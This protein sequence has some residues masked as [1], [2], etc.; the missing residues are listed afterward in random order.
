MPIVD[1]VSEGLKQA[2][3]DKDKV[4][5]QALRNIR[6]AFLESLKAEGAP[7]HLSDDDAVAILRRLAKQRRESIEAYRAG[8]RADLVET[9]QAEL[10]IID[11][12]LPQL[13]D[14]AQ[15]ETWVEQAIAATGATGPGD[16]GKVMGH[17]MKHHRDAIDGKLANQVARA[18]LS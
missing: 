17:L 1:R 3:R 6:A 18:R 10:D 5:L 13:A 12:F 14:R 15:T 16:L 8:D 7:E 11:T 9:E 4:R 2:M